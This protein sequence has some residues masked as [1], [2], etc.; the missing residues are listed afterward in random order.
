M[1]RRVGPLLARLRLTAVL[2]AWIMATTSPSKQGGPGPTS[3]HDATDEQVEWL[4]ETYGRLVF[5]IAMAITHDH[6]LADDV[7]QDT[8]FKAW[9]S[10]PSWDGDVPVK[11][12]RTVARNEA[13]S[14]MRKE[15]RSITSENLDHTA[16]R[17]N[18]TERIVEGRQ[19]LDA[20]KLAME[21]LDEVSRTM[22]VLRESDDLGYEEIAYV[23]GLS[24]SAV[25]AK[26]YRARHQLRTQL[27]DWES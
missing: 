1:I 11:W 2:L 16:D 22:I 20:M 10:L 9:T 18:E 5:R 3:D 23:V 12:L 19:M 24:P 14:I 7:V 26:L 15:R 13:I 8:M 17:A 25:K 4:V 6:D 21:S 27:R